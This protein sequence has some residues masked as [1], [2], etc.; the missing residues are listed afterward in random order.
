MSLPLF[1]SNFTGQWLCHAPIKPTLD[2]LTK[3]GIT[4]TENDPEAMIEDLYHQAQ[5]RGII[6]SDY[7][8]V[9][10]EAKEQDFINLALR[11]ANNHHLKAPE[12]RAFMQSVY[13]TL[14]WCIK[15]VFA[16]SLSNDTEGLCNGL[17]NEPDGYSLADLILAQ[18]FPT[19]DRDYGFLYT[20]QAW[21]VE[22]GIR[23]YLE[24]KVKAQQ[25]LNNFDR[26]LIN[27]L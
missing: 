18:T 26:N 10:G 24:N 27:V 3:R 14:S 20:T 12:Y 15:Q 8:I 19:P 21:D 2:E 4:S 5:E 16:E 7:L 1:L 25:P 23:L 13:K 6:R 9:L 22:A 11:I 17:A